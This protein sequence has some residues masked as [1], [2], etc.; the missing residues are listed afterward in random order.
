MPKSLVTVAALAL[1][2]F[3]LS[4]DLARAQAAAPMATA[5]TAKGPTL[6]DAKGMTLYVFDRDAAGKSACNGACATNWPPALAAANATPTGNWTVVTRDDGGRQWAY[7][8]KPLYG[9][10]KDTK[11]GDVTGDNVNNVWRVARP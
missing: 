2:T 9:W 8:G 4:P 6:V 10:S 1:G 3:V 5:T 11:A 7:K